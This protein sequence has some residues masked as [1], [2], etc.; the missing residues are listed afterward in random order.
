MAMTCK[1]LRQLYE[2]CQTHHLKLSSSDLIR[3][4]CPECG[5]DE[6]CPS[7]LYAEYDARHPETPEIA[8]NSVAKTAEEPA[9]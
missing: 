8:V 7:V 9:D 3:V 1:H 6:V 5:V 4:M 2:M